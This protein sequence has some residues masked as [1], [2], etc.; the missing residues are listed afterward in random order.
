[1]P[2]TVD[3]L[4][5][6]F[7]KQCEAILGID[8]SDEMVLTLAN[9]Q[10]T[11]TNLDS[12]EE[13]LMNLYELAQ[14]EVLELRSNPTF[15]SKAKISSYQALIKKIEGI[16]ADFTEENKVEFRTVQ[17]KLSHLNSL[18]DVLFLLEQ[19]KG[20]RYSKR[21]SMIEQEIK[22]AL[23][24]PTEAKSTQSLNQIRLILKDTDI[25]KESRNKHTQELFDQMSKI[26]GPDTSLKSD[27]E[28]TTR[29]KK[30]YESFYDLLEEKYRDPI[31][32]SMCDATSG[33]SFNA[34]LVAYETGLIELYSYARD[35]GP[36]ELSQRVIHTIEQESKTFSAD[37]KRLFNEISTQKDALDQAQAPLKSLHTAIK[38]YQKDFRSRLTMTPHRIADIDK[39]IQEV[40][41]M[42]ANNREEISKKLDATKAA[43]ASVQTS[44]VGTDGQQKKSSRSQ[45]TQELYHLCHQI[46]N[47]TV[48][49][50]EDQQ[51]D[52][53]GHR[54]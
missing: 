44:L 33:A 21:I 22:K 5:A 35:K 9:I 20:F 23:H 16:A 12:L 2:K 6:E 32:D 47:N 54:L 52:F 14:S 38:E 8:D 31:L 3:A 26:V 41:F 10:T 11:E 30:M 43:I 25:L 29:L 7:D 39:K 34:P 19:H 40:L 37:G 18:K 27:R 51:D 15:G 1:M 50:I 49:K 28:Q 53:E 36:S 4:S 17:D 45:R 13:G 42:P 48:R 46:L 24:R